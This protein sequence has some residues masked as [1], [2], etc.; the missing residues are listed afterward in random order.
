MRRN[1]GFVLLTVFLVIVTGCS[2]GGVAMCQP[3]EQV[4]VNEQYYTAL[5]EAYVREVKALLEASG[6]KHAGVMLTHVR[7]EDGSRVY[8]L[9]VHHQNYARLA[10]QEQELLIDA[11]RECSFETERCTFVQHFDQ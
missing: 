6:L 3:K 9:S 4:R 5:E 10:H 1:A 2:M 7:E 8:T 11:V